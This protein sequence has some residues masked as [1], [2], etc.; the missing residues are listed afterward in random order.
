M[1]ERQQPTN[2]GLLATHLARRRPDATGEA[3]GALSERGTALRLL[4]APASTLGVDVGLIVLLAI[5]P[6]N[7]DHCLMG[8]HGVAARGC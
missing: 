2:S 1:G 6:L 3:A 7:P 4:M 8:D 5:W